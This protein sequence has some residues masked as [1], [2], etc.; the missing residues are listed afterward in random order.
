MSGS[1]PVVRR[2]GAADGERRLLFW[3][4]LSTAAMAVA[5][6]ALG[7][8][9]LPHSGPNCRSACVGYPYTGGVAFVPRDFWWMYPGSL[10][11]LQAVALL[12]ILPRRDGAAAA[13]AA[14]M[15][16][17]LAAIAAGVLVTDYGIQLT[18]VQPVLLKGETDGIGLLSQYNPHG[19]FI[20]LEDVGYLLLGLAFAAVGVAAA[21]RSRLERVVRGMFGAGGGLTVVA[22]VGYAVGY[23]ADLEYRFEVAGIAVDWLVLLVTGVLLAVAY[24]SRRW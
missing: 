20:A 14:R 9:T 16:V 5:A 23:R 7:I 17:A 1:A 21:A 22:L 15:S 12:M 2:P 24:R 11:V 3:T 19:V 4:A 18:V 6:L 13:L 8:T 10:V